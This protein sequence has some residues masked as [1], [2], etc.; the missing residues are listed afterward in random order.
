MKTRLIILINKLITL[1]AKML[2][3]QASVF[4]ASI[5]LKLDRNVLEKIKYPKYVI[6]VTGSSG[7]GS[8]TSMIAHILEESGYK[9]AWNKS[10]SNVLNGC[11]TLILNKSSILTKKV[12]ADVLL[13]EMDESYIKETFKKST[14]THLVVTN[15]T[16]DQPARNASPDRILNKIINSIDN[17]THLILNADD[18]IVN[19][20]TLKH[21][22]EIT[23]FGIEETKY[24]LKKPISNN[25]DAAYCPIC[26][27]KLTYSFYHYGHLG[28][29][30]CD[31][32]NYQRKVD[33]KG[34]KV[35]LEK[36]EM[37]IQNNKVH[38]NKP[39]FFAA[40]YTLAAYTL[41]SVINIKEENILKALN[42]NI[43]KTDR[44]KTIKLDSRNVIMIE[45]K[46]ENNLSYLQS[47]NIINDYKGKKT[48]I[49]GFDNVSRRYTYNDISWLYDVDF[50]IL[51]TDNIDK[52]FIIGR[53][54]FD[55]ASRLISSNINE[56]KI[57]LVNDINKIVPML[58]EN[59]TGTIFTMV[60]FDMTERLEKLFEET[61][62]GE[63]DEN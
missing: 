30:K 53:F 48:I 62:E 18:P 43:L 50:N 6:G 38:L 4:P 10:G 44:M 13:L 40:Y 9:V 59:T 23:T 28:S 29:Y 17:N 61:E 56:D 27:F 3:K 1:F 31:K 60:C 20:M 7:K 33:F 16:R 41:T 45:S 34:S 52:I 22:G 32:C 19:K 12:K 14:L 26:N 25:L 46:N 58:R 39:A 49:L 42:T 11:A 54:R 57:I 35:D 8:T 21:K 37:E 24:S 51:N 47:L 2:G 55:V 5:S 15:I 63:K 36:Q